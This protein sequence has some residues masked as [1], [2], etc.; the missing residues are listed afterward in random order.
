MWRSLKPFCLHQFLM[1]IPIYEW[2]EMR[3]HSILIIIVYKKNI[4]VLKTF[5]SSSVS[6]VDSYNT[7]IKRW[8]F[9]LYKT[10]H[11]QKKGR[12][13]GKAEAW[14]FLIL[15]ISTCF[16]TNCRVKSR[17]LWTWNQYEELTKNGMA[18]SFDVTSA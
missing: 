16:L 9:I 14:N 11:V 13:T 4:D 10:Y 3:I 5:L 18:L 6:A 7:N 8:G 1:W 15:L 2:K 17:S 12:V